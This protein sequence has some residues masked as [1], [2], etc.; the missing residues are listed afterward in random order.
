MVAGRVLSGG[1]PVEGAVVLA[2]NV[3]G[4]VVGYGMSD[5][6]GSYS[7]DGIPAGD[8]TLSVHREGFESA[9]SMLPVATAD[10]RVNKDFSLAIATAVGEESM[11]P[12]TYSLDQNFPN[13][14]NPTTVIRYSLPAVSQVRLAVFDMLGRQVS[15]LVNEKKE[16]GSYEVK[17]DATGLASG[18][19]FYRIEAGTFV[20]TRKLLVLR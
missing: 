9:A 7:I 2:T 13:P 3:A 6:S 18:V 14:F 19:Y 4:Q 15:E 10:F 17:F 12:V 1:V 16:A 8:L 11:V 5:D 20:Q